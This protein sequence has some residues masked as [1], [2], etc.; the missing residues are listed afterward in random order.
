MCAESLWEMCLV[1]GGAVD[2]VLEHGLASLIPLTS[3]EAPARHFSSQTPAHQWAA[4]QR[5]S[6]PCRKETFMLALVFDGCE[7]LGTL[8]RLATTGGNPAAPALTR[9]ETVPHSQGYAHLS[10][11]AIY[12]RHFDLI[13]SSVRRLG[14][15]GAAVD[16]VVQEVFIVIHSRIHTL[17]QRDSLRSWIYG[18]VRR[19][20]SHHHRSQR[21]HDVGELALEFFDETHP[22]SQPTPFDHTSRNDQLRLLAVVLR[23]LDEPR[24]EIFV[25]AELEEM[26]VPEIAKALG[27]PLNTVYSRLRVARQIFEQALARQLRE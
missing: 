18:I 13:W 16:D 20:V 8:L 2:S 5:T 6:L 15:R 19:T 7:P 1:V 23:K 11:A 27:I 9:T 21:A 22:S 26:T 3:T 12:E 25:L 10:F 17:Q 4:C 24:R 14:V